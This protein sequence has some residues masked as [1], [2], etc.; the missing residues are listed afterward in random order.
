MKK[1]LAG[2]FA[3]LLFV[4]TFGLTACGNDND[5]TYYPPNDEIKANLTKAGYTTDLHDSQS[6][7]GGVALKGDDYIY[8]YRPNTEAMCENY[9]NS[10]EQSCKNYDALVKIVNDKKY[11]NIVYCGTTKAINDAGIKVVKVDVE[12]KV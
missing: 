7:W 5:G 6:G 9:Y 8:F 2:L 12:V 3:C 10:C 11:G 1:I 4:M